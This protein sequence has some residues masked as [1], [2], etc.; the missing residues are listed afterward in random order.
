MAFTG[1]D[2]KFTFAWQRSLHFKTLT[3]RYRI[4]SI[5]THQ[6]WNTDDMRNWRPFKR[7]AF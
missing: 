2:N 7:V 5:V 6:E 4:F 3:D 1:N